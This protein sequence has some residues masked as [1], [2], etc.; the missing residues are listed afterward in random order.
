V[1]TTSVTRPSRKCANACFSLEASP[2]KSMMAASFAERAGGEFLLDGGERIVHRIHEDAA[3]KI[4][5]EDA[6]ARLCFKKIG[7]AAW[8]SARI[9]ERPDQARLMG[10]EIKRLALVEGVIAERHAIG[11]SAKKIG[12]NSFGNAEAAGGVFAVDHD[13]IEVPRDTQLRQFFQND[14]ATSTSDDITYE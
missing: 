13:A 6:R 1:P 10:Y 3:E 7:A 14:G 4:G 5:D 2:W 12:A 11:A 9:V 8:R